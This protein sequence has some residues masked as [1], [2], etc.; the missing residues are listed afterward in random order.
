[1]CIAILNSNNITFSKSLI[2]NC[3]ENNPDGAGLIWTDT[4][5]RELFI[6]KE[7]HSVESYYNQYID[8]RRKHPKSQIV[9]HFRIS[10]SGGV[11]ETNTH[12][13][14]VN[15]RLAFVHNG[16]ISELNGKE[17]GRSDTNLFNANF[18]QHLPADF[19]EN[20]A[21]TG[22]ISKFIGSSKLIFLNADNQAHIIN[23]S[24]GKTDAKYPNCWFSNSTYEESRFYDVGGVKVYKDAHKPKYKGTYYGGTYGST[25]G[26]PYKRYEKGDIWN[27]A[28]GVWEAPK[29]KTTVAQATSAV[30]QLSWTDAS[31]GQAKQYTP[32]QESQMRKLA[33]DARAIDNKYSKRYSYLKSKGY[34][35]LTE[36][37]WEELQELELYFTPF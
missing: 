15:E 4:N 18:L 36:S 11:N 19:L 31:T 27:D 8:I 28:R 5:T 24:L 33:E 23:P 13:F 21:L 34:A 9:L 12:P 2:S 26:Q 32:A 14:Q 1:M 7:L 37:E 35:T 16:I 25:Y 3:W 6:Y 20:S 29:A 30:K 17:A 10:T 22:L